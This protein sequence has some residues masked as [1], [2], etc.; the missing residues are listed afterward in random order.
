MA[1]DRL[2][3]EEV[4]RV[5]RRAAELDRA[6]LGRDL[7]GGLPVEAVEAAAAE[8]G[9]APAAVRQAVAELRAG[10]LD[11]QPADVDVVCARVVPGEPGAVLTS[12]GRWLGSQAL[13][14]T[15]DR[16]REQVWRPRED[17]VAALQRRLDL[18]GAI[19][20]RRVEE[21]VVRTVEVEGGTLVRLVARLERSVRAAPAVGSG[22]GATAGAVAGG[23]L[24]LLEP[25]LALAAAPGAAVGGTVGWR[26]GRGVRARDRR[27]AAEAL[28]GVLDELELGREPAAPRAFDRLA[29]RARRLRGGYRL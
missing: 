28:D 15:R 22:V 16:G 6:A 17:V 24:A 13:V 25:E 5:L 23:V 9:L 1:D 14:R 18:A 26:I 21:V 19:R 11:P 4:A 7:A 12:V 8:V 20:L 10:A 3:D 29:A 27:R 2:T